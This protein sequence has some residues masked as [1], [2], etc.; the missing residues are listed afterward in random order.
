MPFREVNF[1]DV[2][3]LTHP[4]VYTPAE[5]SFLLAKAVNALAVGKVLDVGT[6][7]GIQAIT[8]AKKESVTKVVAVDV[9]EAALQCAESNAELNK[10]KEKI[11]FMRS[12]LFDRV[13]GVYDTIIFN[14][15]YVPVEPEEK[16][17]G[18]SMAWHG[19]TD[20]RSVL[21]PFLSSF[22]SFLTPKGQLLLLQSSLNDLEKTTEKLKQL[23]FSVS[24]H[25]SEAFFFEKI[26]VLIAKR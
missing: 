17:D 13:E 12:N 15:P 9:N 24:I 10:V 23:G 18:E 14:P 25:S 6:G 2:K 21:E 22:A 5:D 8:A 20:G 1:G 16:L 7:S 3:I 26:Y 4:P 11:N 19:G